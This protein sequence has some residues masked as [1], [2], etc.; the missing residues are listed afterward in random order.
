MNINRLCCCCYRAIEPE[1][2]YLLPRSPN[3]TERHF[4]D[5]ISSGSKVAHK[6]KKWMMDD[7]HP[8]YKTFMKVNV[9]NAKM[10]THI[11]NR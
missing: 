10:K 9:V 6:Y 3:Y 7:K 4:C 1:N 11:F 5:L 8:T 2:N